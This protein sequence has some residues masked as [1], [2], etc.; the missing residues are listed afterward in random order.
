MERPHQRGIKVAVLD[1]GLDFEHPDYAGRPIHS[2][3]F[4]PRETQR[5]GHGHGTH[6]AVTA[7]GGRPNPDGRRYG[8]APEVD[9]H[10][11]KVLSNSGRGGD[12]NVLAGINWAV[13]NRV[14]IVSMSLGIS[15]RAVSTA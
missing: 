11:G 5:D 6:C 8:V 13:A 7:C 1:T 10:V 2:E 15:I 12:A 14:H 3:S 9:L 4:I